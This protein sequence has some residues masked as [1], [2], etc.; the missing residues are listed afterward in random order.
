M[1]KALVNGKLV[2]AALDSSEV[3]V[4][5][6][7]GGMVT[8]RKRRKLDGQ[9]TYYYRHNRGVGQDCARRYQC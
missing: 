1:R 2:A 5:P 6:S 8:K 9:T 7:C 3:A 4:C